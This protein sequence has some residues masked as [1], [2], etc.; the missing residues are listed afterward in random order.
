VRRIGRVALF[1]ELTAVVAVNKQAQGALQRIR[2]AR[3]TT[4]RSRQTCQV[5]PQL[6]IVSFNRVGIGFTFRNSIPAIVIPQVIIGI[7]CIAEI[8]FGLGRSIN[9]L[10]NILLRALPDNF[11]AQITARLPVYDRDDVD[12]VFLLPI[13]VNSSSI[14]AILTSSGTGVSGKLATLALTHSETVR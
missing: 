6:G 13:K 9:H 11:A 12:P 3:E 1:I 4:R 8:L 10:L 2:T 14:S 7:K 5:V